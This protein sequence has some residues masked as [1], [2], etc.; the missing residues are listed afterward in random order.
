MT[1]VLIFADTER[2]ADMRHELPLMIPDPFLYAE[3]GGARHAVMASYECPRVLA[4]EDGV[5]A[6]ALEEFGLDDLLAAGLSH[7]EATLETAVRACRALGITAAV[8]P[9]EFPL[10]LA[11]RL[12]AADVAITADRGTF[13]RRRRVKSAAELAGIRRAQAAADAGMEAA[14]ALLRAAEPRGD[15]LVAGGET[16]TCEL[17]KQVIRD[18][19]SAAGGNQG[20]EMIV[21]HGAQTAIGHEFG[22]GPIAAGE[23]VVVDLWPRDRTSACSADMTR[24]FVVGEAPEKIRQYHAL[25]RTALERAKAG[26]RDGVAAQE[27]YGLA[28]EPYEE[29]GLPTQRTKQPGEVLETGFYHSLGHG[30]G[31]QVHEAPAVGRTSDVL[32]E[33]DVITLEP[34]CYDFDNGGCR[35]EDVVLVTKDG[36]ETITQFPYELEP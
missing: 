21:S 6:H 34:G 35:L 22:S 32:Q 26:V 2:S 30:V 20:D 17:L 33:G 15:G 9:W 23:P 16:L 14:A 8:V 24:T 29:A 1:D 27:V 5:D 3:V 13:E 25:T 7:T 10:D 11:D 4:V 36:C 28:C 12:R 19:I 18:A 31:L